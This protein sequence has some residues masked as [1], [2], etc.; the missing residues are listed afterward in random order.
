MIRGE[1][2]WRQHEDGNTVFG[3]K[4]CHGHR[5]VLNI[6]KLC[7]VYIYLYNCNVILK[8]SIF[9]FITHLKKHVAYMTRERALDNK[10][11]AFSLLK[12]TLLI[13]KP[14][15]ITPWQNKNLRD[16]ISHLKNTYLFS[17]ETMSQ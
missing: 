2:C 16:N 14:W 3:N 8:D 5:E 4:F 6:V 10:Q 15:L 13:K 17:S 7:T 11:T 1:D 9:I 12:I